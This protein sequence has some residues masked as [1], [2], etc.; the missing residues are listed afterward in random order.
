MTGARLLFVIAMA[1]TSVRVVAWFRQR[2][3]PRARVSVAA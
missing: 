2:R 3:R 1:I